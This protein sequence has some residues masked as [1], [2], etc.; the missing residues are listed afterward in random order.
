MHCNTLFIL[1]LASAV[2]DLPLPAAGMPTPSCLA[3]PSCGPVPGESS[4]YSNFSSIEPPWPGNTTGAVMNTTGGLPGPDDML[5]QNLL[6]A[7]WIIFSFYQQ[8]VEKFNESVFV[9]AG[10]PNTTYDRI[11]EIRNNE[12]GHLRIFQDQISSNSVKPGPC[13]YAYPF[14]DVTSFLALQT[15][16]EVSSMAFLTGLELQAKSTLSRGALVAISSTETRHNTWSLIDNWKT[17]PFAGPS[18]TF[19]PYANQV[20]DYTREWVI[21][22]SCPPQ[23]PAYPFPNQDLPQISP[24]N[25]T[26]KTLMP[27][28]DLT[29]E[30]YGGADPLCFDQDQ[31]YFAVFFHGV[32]NVS[33]PFD[34]VSKTTTIPA[35][36]EPKGIFAL[37]I[38]TVMGAPTAESVV[39]GPLIL[40]EDPQS[41]GL[42]ILS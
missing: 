15:L 29:L 19:F 26:L 11:R 40:L 8:G 4:I 3:D 36:L 14:T 24:K 30:F 12:A 31:D 35:A 27:G 18:D 2:V 17:N 5:F 41:L 9:A 6:A 42:M 20:L 25:G 16:I 1:F 37:V 10:F 38:A 39:A 33:V 21:E 13:K 32:L 28:S 23:N 34:T 22:G 7:E